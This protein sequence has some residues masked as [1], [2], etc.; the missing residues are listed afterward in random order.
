MAIFP[1]GNPGRHP[2]DPDSDVGK[3]RILIGDTLSEPYDPV[4][5]GIQNY[6]MF[7]DAELEGFLLAGDES[8]FRAAGFAYLQLAARAAL[9]SKSVKDYDLSLDVTKR[10]NDLREIARMWFQRADDEDVDEGG[11][12]I[13]DM[14][15][16]GGDDDFVP[17]GTIAVWGRK[18]VPGRWR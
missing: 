11:A 17:E 9:E 4:E 7:S 1:E 2:L 8:L 14:F 5:P 16:L 15:P 13:F 12:D 3:L 18:Y 10:S 6:Q